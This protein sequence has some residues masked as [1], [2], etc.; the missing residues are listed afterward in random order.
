LSDK[1]LEK[2]QTMKAK[3]EKAKVRAA[4][5]AAKRDEK[6][7][8]FRG[9]LKDALNKEIKVDGMSLESARHY[10]RFLESPRIMERDDLLNV[11]PGHELAEGL[12]K[13]RQT[14]NPETPRDQ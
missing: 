3:R 6:P 13:S 4:A 5:V 12:M 11:I 2:Y 14:G 10:S 1:I 8:S 9:L 7:L